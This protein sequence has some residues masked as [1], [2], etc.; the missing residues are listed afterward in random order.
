MNF[1]AK[2]ATAL[3]FVLTLAACGGGAE[4]ADDT[5]LNEPDAAATAALE[6]P[7]PAATL[8]PAATPTPGATPSETP[9]AGATPS[10]SPTP[11][12]SATPTRAAATPSPAATPKRL[13]AS[14][15]PPAFAQ[16][17]ACHAVAPGR[18]GLGP[19][20]AGVFGDRAASQSGFDYTEALEN[21]G[22]TWN[23]ANLHRYLTNPMGTVPGTKMAYPG[24]RDTAQRQA[25]IDY[26]KSL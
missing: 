1:A 19:S 22:L 14:G 9:T 4:E 26:M 6:V 2:S 15:P 18:H 25:V 13:A 3:A 5:R 8:V 17:S 23:E 21:S 20:L 10:P 16:C 24:L 7:D 11:S 12:P